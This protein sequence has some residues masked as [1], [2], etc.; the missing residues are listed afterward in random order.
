MAGAHADFEAAVL[1]LAQGQA[2]LHTLDGARQAGQVLQL[3]P[4]HTRRLNLIPGQANQG[5]A[6]I[7]VELQAFQSHTLRNDACMGAALKQALVERFHVSPGLNEGGGGAVGLC[8]GVAEPE[9]AGIGCHAGVQ[10]GG[11]L[12]RNLR[13]HLGDECCQQLCGSRCMVIHQRFIRIAA[14]GA[15][16]VNAQIDVLGIFLNVVALPEQLDAGHIHRHHKGGGE[17]AVKHAAGHIVIHGRNR[18]TA[19]HGGILA[20]LLQGKA[21]R[22]AGADGIA[23][24]ILVAQYQDVICSQQTRNNCLAVHI[25]S[26]RFLFSNRV[27]SY[28]ASE[29]DSMSSS[30]SSLLMCAA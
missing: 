7:I 10:A 2:D 17:A 13:A 4:G 25:L 11:N 6:V 30:P 24:R 14:V 21:E 22:R 20:Q 12:R 26:H 18:V 1:L 16:M 15:V 29:S 3:G 8:R 23:V 9:A 27:Q 28:S 5:A 19:Q